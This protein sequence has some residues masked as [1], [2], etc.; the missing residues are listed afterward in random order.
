MT[1]RGVKQSGRIERLT[2]EPLFETGR[3]EHGIEPHRQVEPLAL[4]EERFEI[5]D[6]HLLKRRCLDLLDEGCEI[7]IAAFFPGG[8]EDVGHDRV[9]P[10]AGRPV[11]AGERQ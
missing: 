6:A 4:R 3:G 2:L 10:A 7:E 8:R 9:F 11:H 1:V 5:D